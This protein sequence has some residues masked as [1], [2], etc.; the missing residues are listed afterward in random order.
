MSLMN[1]RFILYYECPEC[2]CEW[3]DTSDS[4]T[5]D[6]C[7]QCGKRHVFPHDVEDNP[8]FEGDEEGDEEGDDDH[9]PCMACGASTHIHMLD[10][11]DDG[12]GNFTILECEA[13]YGPGWAPGPPITPKE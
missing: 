10:A 1:E 8:A 13:C 9:F 11:K 12:T 2:G 4:E 7:P 6:D 3:H 5:D